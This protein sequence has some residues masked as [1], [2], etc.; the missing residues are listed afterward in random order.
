MKNKILM[1]HRFDSLYQYFYPMKNNI[2]AIYIINIETKKI[3]VIGFYSTTKTKLTESEISTSLGKK[4]KLFQRYDVKYS[5]LISP[6]DAIEQIKK[7]LL[8]EAKAEKLF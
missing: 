8:R 1:Y 7:R 4:M 6:I 2:F 3:Q 5:T